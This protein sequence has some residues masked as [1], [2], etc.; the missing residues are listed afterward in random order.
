MSETTNDSE[1]TARARFATISNLHTCS[2]SMNRNMYVPVRQ[3][4]LTLAQAPARKRQVRLKQRQKGNKRPKT[5]VSRHRAPGRQC[6]C[7]AAAGPHLCP[8]AQTGGLC[9]LERSLNR[10]TWKGSERACTSHVGLSSMCGSGASTLTR[11]CRVERSE[12][13]RRCCIAEF[14]VSMQRQIG[15]KLELFSS[16]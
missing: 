6:C 16:I 14:R 10:V 7:S 12:S 8:Q 4:C 3:H 1:D 13:C 5:T 15:K 9:W 2:C 11:N